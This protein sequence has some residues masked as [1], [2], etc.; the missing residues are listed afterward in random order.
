MKKLA[1]VLMFIL[2][3]TIFVGAAKINT[4]KE[5]DKGETLIAKI[6]GNFENEV[7]EKNIYLYKG[8]EQVPIDIKE[9]IKINNTYFLYAILNKEEGN[10]SLRLKNTYYWDAE[11]II[12]DDLMQNF[13][14][15]NQTA[16]FS[17]KPG[18][19][20]TN[21][22]FK[23]ELTNLKYTSLE[24]EISDNLTKK[25]TGWFG[26]SKDSKKI[27]ISARDKKEI[28]FQINNLTNFSE[29][30]YVIELKSEN[31]NYK[32]P[33]YIKNTSNQEKKE[34]RLKFSINNFQDFILIN[35][36]KYNR[37][38]ELKNIGE[39]EIN[40]IKI[41]I[42]NNLSNFL[43]LSKKIIDSI[44]PGE[45]EKII[46]SINPTNTSEKIILGK[47]TAFSGE[48]KDIIEVK[49]NFTRSFIPNTN[50]SKNES[51]KDY[52]KLNNTCAELGGSICEGKCEG[53][54]RNLEEGNCC[55]GECKEEQKQSSLGQKITGYL[56]LL[57]IIL[58]VAWFFLKKFKPTK[59]EVDL[60]KTAQ[61]GLFS[62]K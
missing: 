4:K 62:K 32:V 26:I 35:S 39:Q 44:Q 8:F 49:L 13:T 14:I 1:L 55:I 41:N 34:K 61:K 17:L 27:N 18:V 31:T 24:V 42:S 60:L 25:E 9:I 46:I 59:R 56:L 45:K 6:T 3:G 50:T 21:R 38:I 40:N 19:I 11:N 57:C 16:D 52:I 54:V 2:L 10:Y 23:L 28:E 22:S 36:S 29:G 48:I 33:V 30:Y 43:T 7:L 15:T 37:T 12:N 5:Y 58:F 53:E 51:L 20:F 47:I